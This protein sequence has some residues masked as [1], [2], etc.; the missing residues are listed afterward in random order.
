MT[1]QEFIESIRLEGEVWKDVVG[2]ERYAISSYG[3]VV[4]YSAP[5]LCG[6]FVC[7]RKPRLMRPS[8]TNSSPNYKIVSLSDGKRNTKSFL[9][10][11]LVAIAF[12]P[13]PNNLPFIN[14]KDEDSLNNRADNLE[15]CTQKY[16][17]NYGTH[18][19]RMAKTIRETAYQK[20][21][22]VQ[23]SKDGVFINKF[24]SV[25]DAANYIGAV[26]SNIGACCQGINKSCKGYKWMYL[27]DYESLVS[28]SKNELPNPDNDYPQ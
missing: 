16:N 17:C 7:H 23:L 25:T 6:K 18:N 27:P 28:M 11:R 22:V 3:R 24:D 10:H 8:Y 1:N 4:A 5:Y 15:W 9:I 13:N 20:R 14:H 2:W 19:A 26:R 21:Q 12:I